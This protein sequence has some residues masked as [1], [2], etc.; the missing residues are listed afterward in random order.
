MSIFLRI[1]TSAI[2]SE[3]C[4]PANILKKGNGMHYGLDLSLR[5]VGTPVFDRLL[6]SMMIIFST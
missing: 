2:T 3:G 6:F 4:L 1:L 5:T